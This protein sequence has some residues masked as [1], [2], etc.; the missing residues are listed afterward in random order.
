MGCM[1]QMVMHCGRYTVHT[2]LKIG[3]LTDT[4]THRQKRKNENRMSASFT[5]KNPFQSRWS[6]FKV[7]IFTTEC[8]KLHPYFRQKFF[9]G[10]T[11]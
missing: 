11:P 5:P 9:R 8:I 1:S 6:L 10:D 2:L 7:R 4:H 3:V